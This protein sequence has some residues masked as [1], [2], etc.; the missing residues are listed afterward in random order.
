MEEVVSVVVFLVKKLVGNVDIPLVIVEEVNPVVA[1]EEDLDWV[2]D[3]D[4]KL[5][6]LEVVLE[7]PLDFPLLGLVDPLS[8]NGRLVLGLLGQVHFLLW[9]TLGKRIH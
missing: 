7:C 8:P 1:P 6:P 2:T 9:N 4:H 3:L 5:C